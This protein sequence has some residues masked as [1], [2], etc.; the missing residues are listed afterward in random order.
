MEDRLVQSILR[1]ERN[2]KGPITL[3]RFTD[4]LRS[5]L[6]ENAANARKA[7]SKLSPNGRAAG[8]SLIDHHFGELKRAEQEDA[9]DKPKSGIVGTVHSLKR[10]NDRYSKVVVSDLFMGKPMASIP[11]PVEVA[12]RLKTGFI[13]RLTIEVY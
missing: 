7:L 5:G 10:H 13:V 4:R 2:R 8:R 6:Y 9:E 12:S 3:A 11:V 1:R